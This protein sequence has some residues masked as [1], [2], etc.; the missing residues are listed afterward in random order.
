MSIRSDAEAA[1][2]IIQ[3]LL[4]RLPKQNWTLADLIEVMLQEAANGP[5]IQTAY[6]ATQFDSVVMAL[7][8]ITDLT[9]NVITGDKYAFE[10]F[11]LTTLDA[12]G[13]GQFDMAGGTATASQAD[14]NAAIV[15]AAG[16]VT[17]NAGN[18]SGLNGNLALAGA[19]T[20]LVHATGSFNCNGS[21]TIVPQFGQGAG[22]NGTS[23][24]LVGS[25]LRVTRVA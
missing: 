25:F 2:V 5:V 8:P 12:V 16:T 20:V 11:A 17:Y 14:W 18:L 10:L 21:G 15:L 7:A 1:A 23:S 13:K 9:A 4:F 6:L 19:T 24:V 22:P 3:P